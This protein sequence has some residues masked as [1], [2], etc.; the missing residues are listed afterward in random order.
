MSKQIQCAAGHMFEHK[1]GRG[2]PPMY[3][4]EHKPAKPASKKSGQGTAVE[5]STVNPPVN[6]FIKRAHQKKMAELRAKRDEKKERSQQEQDA[7]EMEKLEEEYLTIDEK[8]D[9][10][11]SAY[12][13]SFKAA[14]AINYSIETA[15]A[16]NKAWGKSDRAQY[17][18]MSLLSRKRVIEARVEQ[19]TAPA[20]SSK[21]PITNERA[22]AKELPEVLERIHVDP[23][24]DVDE[25]YDD[26]IAVFASMEDDD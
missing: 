8:I 18:L 20:A 6:P 24:G 17:T 12:T 4:P 22:E 25:S 10:A 11:T 26:L 9:S 7:A 2:R 15:D 13:A 21:S 23:Y 16:F 14:N 1:G 19:L 3:C 5:G